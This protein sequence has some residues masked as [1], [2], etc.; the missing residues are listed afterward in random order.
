MEQIQAFI[1]WFRLL[2]TDFNTWLK[3]TVNFDG[4]IMDLYT[5]YI[6]PLDEWIK[7]VGF[8]GVV[9]LVILGLFGAIKKAYK[10]ILIVLLV[11]ILLAVL[12]IVL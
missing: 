3:N 1:D 6:E 2:F 5:T 10:L 8:F 9:I 11:L 4:R 12:S 7:I